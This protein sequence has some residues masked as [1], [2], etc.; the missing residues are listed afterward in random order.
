[1]SLRPGHN[2][3]VILDY[4]NVKKEDAAKAFEKEKKLAQADGNNNII[5]VEKENDGSVTISNVAI[6]DKKDLESFS[7][8]QKVS[9]GS[10]SGVIALIDDKEDDEVYQILNPENVEA[11][12]KPAGKTGTVNNVKQ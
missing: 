11:K 4:H 1:M 6:P 8:G 5:L 9:V 12:E 10:A 7:I 2:I 3:G